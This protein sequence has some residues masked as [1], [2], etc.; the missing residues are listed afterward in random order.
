MPWHGRALALQLE[1]LALHGNPPFGSPV[2]GRCPRRGGVGRPGTTASSGTSGGL[3]QA[4]DT[5]HRVASPAT[6]AITAPPR[7]VAG[8]IAVRIETALNES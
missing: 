2:I 4:V 7:A 6:I 8:L 1:H 3:S 5:G